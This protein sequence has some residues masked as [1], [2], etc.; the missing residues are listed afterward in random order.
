MSIFAFKTAIA[1][2]VGTKVCLLVYLRDFLLLINVKAKVA[3]S[4]AA[5]SREVGPFVD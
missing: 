1:Q 4:S 3:P 5:A 2:N